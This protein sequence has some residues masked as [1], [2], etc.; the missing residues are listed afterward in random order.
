VLND[1]ELTKKNIDSLNV[2]ELR[3]LL[4]RIGE[5]W[6]NRKPLRKY[7]IWNLPEEV[8]MWRLAICISETEIGV[9]LGLLEDKPRRGWTEEAGLDMIALKRRI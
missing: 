4:H 6:D 8:I 5:A 3:D 2:S 7:S 1:S 9:K